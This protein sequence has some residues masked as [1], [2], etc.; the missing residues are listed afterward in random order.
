[1]T[2]Y[3]TAIVDE[4]GEPIYWLSDISESQCD[5]ILESHPDWH[6]ECIC[7]GDDFV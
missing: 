5:S 3:R 1:M 6:L 7:I 4:L 2:Y